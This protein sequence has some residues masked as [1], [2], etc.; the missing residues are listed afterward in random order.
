MRAV[1]VR[2]V[3]PSDLI[4]INRLEDFMPLVL[5]NSQYET[6]VGE[7]GLI[8]N[9]TYNFGLLQKKVFFLVDNTFQAS[10]DKSAF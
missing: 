10:F 8:H 5:E 7:N 6:E 1:N 2:D 3:V 4:Q 9:I